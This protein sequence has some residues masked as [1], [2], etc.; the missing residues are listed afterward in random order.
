MPRDRRSWLI[1]RF[2]RDE[3]F[4]VAVISG[5]RRISRSLSFLIKRAVGL[6]EQVV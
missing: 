4:R 3:S 6:N 1:D 5:A 2:D